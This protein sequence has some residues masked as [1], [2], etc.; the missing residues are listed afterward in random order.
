VI[1]ESIADVGGPDAT[2][3]LT[4]TAMRWPSCTTLAAA[5][6]ARTRS[7]A[8]QRPPPCWATGDEFLA[9]KAPHDIARA[10]RLPRHFGEEFQNRVTSGVSVGVID[11]FEPIEIEGKD[12]DRRHAPAAAGHHQPGSGFIEAAPIQQAGQGIRGRCYFVAVHRAVFCKIQ[13]DQSRS[14]H[15]QQISIAKI[16][17]QPRAAL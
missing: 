16:A 15:I 12:A 9:A 2:P 14:D 1:N 6:A 5:N 4:V 17:I 13:H 7:A 3:M 11:R 8:M 10:K